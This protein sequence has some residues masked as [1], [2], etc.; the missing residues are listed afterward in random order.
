MSMKDTIFGTAAP[1]S[2][3][4]ATYRDS[5]QA[6]LPVKNIIGGVVITKDNRFIKILEVLPVNFYLK[7]PSDQQNIIT[8]YAAYLKI[9]PD[10][11]SCEVRTLPPDTSE[12]VEQMRQLYRISK[13]ERLPNFSAKGLA[14]YETNDYADEE[15]SRDPEF[16]A[17]LSVSWELDLWGNLRWAKRKGG[18]EYLSSVEDWRAMRMT[19]VA[20]VATAY[21]QLMALDNELSIVRRTLRTRSEGVQQ[22]QLRFEGG[23][24]SETVYQQA[25]VEYASTATL[26]PDLE[27]RIEIMENSIALL[28]GKSPDWEVLRGQMNIE[29]EFPDSLPVGLP[30]GLL[31]RRPDV[32]ASEQQL[33]SAMASAGMAYADRFPRLTFNLVGGW[34]N[35][36]LQGF[37]RS[38]FSYVA[39]AI[40]APVFGFGRKQAKYRAALAA[41]DVARLGYEKKVLEVF[42]EANDAVVTYRNVRKTAALK[43][44]LRDA[45]R[46][47]VELANLQYR[48]GSINYIDVLDAQRRYFDAQIGLS[49][50]VRDEHLALVQLYKALGGGWELEE[51]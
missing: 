37:F 44:A 1:T 16:S 38:P 7:S 3:G 14:D 32:R 33:R 45:A 31:Q 9:A 2:H 28:M 34:E 27:S 4:G 50:A 41:Y 26:I 36:A 40:A 42:K 49:N 19:L 20:E 5:I 46:K 24:T 30:S 35:D 15:S 13:A 39:G 43:V 25:K 18:A 17:K 21:F 23:L 12:Y 47:Y 10:S 22:A 48:G 11:M 29:A 51:E 6:W 8:S